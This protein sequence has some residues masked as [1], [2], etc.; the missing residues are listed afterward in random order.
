MLRAEFNPYKSF[1]S[2][3]GKT[4]QCRGDVVCKNMGSEIDLGEKILPL[5]L[6]KVNF[7]SL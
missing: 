3:V 2:T 1:P 6:E 4:R 5:G 7:I